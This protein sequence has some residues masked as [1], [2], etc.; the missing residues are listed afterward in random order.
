MSIVSSA[1]SFVKCSCLGISIIPSYYLG[2]GGWVSVKALVAP[3]TLG[4]VHTD[5]RALYYLNIYLG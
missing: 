4:I 2:W 1:N 5:L 3:D